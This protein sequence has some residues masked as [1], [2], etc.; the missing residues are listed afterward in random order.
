ML[1]R[2]KGFPKGTRIP[3]IPNAPAVAPRIRDKKP[4]TPGPSAVG[5]HLKRVRA[6]QNVEREPV[7][8]K[9]LGVPLPKELLTFAKTDKTEPAPAP[10]ADLR[11]EALPFVPTAKQNVASLVPEWEVFIQEKKGQWERKKTGLPG[12]AQSMDGTYTSQYMHLLMK[13][14]ALPVLV[15]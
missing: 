5:P 11:A 13:E 9:P 3:L 8:P 2:S 6:A 10:K 14:Q 7:E 15:A 4:A 12:I 1:F